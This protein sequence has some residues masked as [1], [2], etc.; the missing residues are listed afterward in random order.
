MINQLY[1]ISTI[2]DSHTN[3]SNSYIHA[4]PS[5]PPPQIHPPSHAQKVFPLLVV[6]STA[7]F[8]LLEDL[9]LLHE[10][11]DYYRVKDAYCYHEHYALWEVIEI[12]DSY[13]A[14]Q[15]ETA[16]DKTSSS[17]AYARKKGITLVV[18]AEDMQKRKN[19]VKARTT[20]LLALPDEHQLRFRKYETAKELWDAILKIFGGNV[21]T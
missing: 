1:N 9:P 20:L 2:L 13:K 17:E 14:P 7:E 3:P 4:L 11:K 18:T 15:E 6:S 8:P 19:D 5:P 21:A 12:G 10:D 16:K